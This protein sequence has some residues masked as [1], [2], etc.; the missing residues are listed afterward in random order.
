MRVAV[1]YTGE[2]RTIKKTIPFLKKNLL[3]NTYVHI[4]ATLQPDENDKSFIEENLKENLK[5]L[6]W[7]EKDDITWYINKEKMLSNMDIEE[8][9]KKYLRNG[10]SMIEYYQLY[11][12]YKQMF[13]FEIANN[14]EYD[15]IVRCRTDTI[16]CQP[17]DFSWLSLSEEEIS[18]RLKYIQESFENASTEKILTYFMSTITNNI[19]LK[20]INNNELIYYESS[21][22]KEHQYLNKNDVNLIEFLKTG[23][24]ESLKTYIKKGLYILTI[25]KNLLYIVNRK[26]F[27]LIPFIGISYGMLNFFKNEHWWN[28]ESQFRSACAYSQLSIFNYSSLF[29]EN[30]LYQ[31]DEKNYFNEE[32]ELKKNNILYC[33]IRH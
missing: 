11:L 5:S 25:R 10:G 28:A 9:Y 29:E 18:F 27:S 31:Y 8:T 15:Y 30:S 33:L 23:S 24:I 3:L 6:I 17:I 16:F 13:L 26:L 32:G 12:S 7:L 21:F 14:F 20:N 19:L 1:I 2:I 22:P 4:F